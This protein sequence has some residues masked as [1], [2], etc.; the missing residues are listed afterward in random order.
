MLQKIL[1]LTLAPTLCQ[2]VCAMLKY[3][4]SFTELVSSVQ[5]HQKYLKGCLNCGFVWCSK[6]DILERSLL[7]RRW[8]RLVF[9]SGIQSALWTG[10]N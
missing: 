3:F 9:A 1:T 6:K 4:D 7:K 10:L 5:K 8:S 2:W